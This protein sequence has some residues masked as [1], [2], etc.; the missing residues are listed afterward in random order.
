[1]HWVR[2]VCVDSPRFSA[3]QMSPALRPAQWTGHLLDTQKKSDSK[4]SFISHTTLE[5]FN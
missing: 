2:N 4:L 5:T 1:M 3:T